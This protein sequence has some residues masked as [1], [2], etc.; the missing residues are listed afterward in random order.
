MTAKEIVQQLDGMSI[1]AATR[2]LEQ[3]IRLLT[4]TQRVSKDSPLFKDDEVC[5]KPS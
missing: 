3:A 1:D 4:S 5:S 2:T